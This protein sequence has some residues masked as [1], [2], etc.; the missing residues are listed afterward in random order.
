MTFYQVICFMGISMA[1]AAPLRR[2]S[3]MNLSKRIWLLL[4]FCLLTNE[5]ICRRSGGLSSSFGRGSS[6]ARGSSSIGLGRGSGGSYNRGNTGYSSGRQVGGGSYPSNYGSRTSGGSSGGNFGSRGSGNIGR[7]TNNNRGTSS[8]F[9]GNRGTSNHGGHKS[10]FGSTFKN[11]IVGAAAGYLAYQG[12]KYLIRNAMSPMMY[13]NRPYY[14]G[15]SYYQSRPNTQ[16]CRMPV[17][18]ND[19]NFGNIYFQD[20][21]RPREIVWSCGMHEHC[22]G[23]ECCP[24]GG[25][26]GGMPMNGGGVVPYGG[27]GMPVGGAALPPYCKV[28]G[29]GIDLSLRPAQSVGVRGQLKCNGMPAGG[30]LVKLYDH[31]TFT[32]DDLIAEGRTDAQG[33]FCIAGHA[34]EITRITPKFNI[35][36]DCNDFLPC[37]RKVSV[38]IPQNF[39]SSGQVP[40]NI[41][42]AGMMELAGTTE[43]EARDCFH[44]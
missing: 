12:G 25:M 9:F 1:I 20:Q 16:M 42:D 29:T 14:W 33:N 3:T 4:I 10:G 11:V 5:V 24:N 19:P 13:N 18:S 32:L 28:E 26:G 22:C 31:D 44:K 43:G 27:G 30:I 2:G 37:Q 41:Y 36:H 15:S 6:G 17:E 35:Y 38:Y 7:N 23:Y 8:G 34:N 39:V 21:S 40:Y